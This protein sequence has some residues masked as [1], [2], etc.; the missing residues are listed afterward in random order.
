MLKEKQKLTYHNYAGLPDDKRYELIDGELYMVP[1]PSVYHQLVQGNLVHLFKAFLNQ[2]P[3]GVLL[4]APLDVVLDQSMVLQPDLCFIG[5]DR[6]HIV[7][8]ANIQGAP[9]LVVEILSPGTLERDR[10]VKRDLYARHGVCE[11]WMVDPVGR[12][13]EVLRRN[14]QGFQPVGVYFFEDRIASGLL[15]GFSVSVQEIFAR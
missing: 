3:L 12:C 5:R 9:D 2:H 14:E 13:I 1:S 11:Y 6:E 7:T 8:E 4:Q 15:P 10:L